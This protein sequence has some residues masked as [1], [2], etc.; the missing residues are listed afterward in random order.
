MP[1]I[2]GIVK[3]YANQNRLTQDTNKANNKAFRKSLTTKMNKDMAGQDETTI[4]KAISVAYN[5]GKT[6]ADSTAWD[7]IRKIIPAEFK[8]V[9]MNA[10]VSASDGSLIVE[11]VSDDEPETSTT[12]SK[13]P[14]K[15]GRKKGVENVKTINKRK[16][17][18]AYQQ[19]MLR[20]MKPI[21]IAQL[22]SAQ[23]LCVV[24]RPRLVKNPKT[25]KLERSGELRQE[26]NP[27]EILRLLEATESGEIIVGEDVCP[28]NIK[29]ID[30]I[31]KNIKIII[32]I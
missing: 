25:K 7:L 10:T 31:S 22:Q 23:G 9:G 24:L 30:Q 5:E 18:T 1:T 14:E 32:V 3:D 27:D 8:K 28:K 4:K 2:E 16:A 11:P 15:S 26:K 20:M 17:L 29:I 19:Q 12:G 13:K 6:R 21:M